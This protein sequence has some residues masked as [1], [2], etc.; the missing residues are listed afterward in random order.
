MS[1]IAKAIDIAGTQAKL[2]TLL[3]DLTGKTV[4]QQNVSSWLNSRV[5]AEWC[6]PISRATGVPLSELRPDVYEAKKPRQ[7]AVPDIKQST[8]MRCKQVL[9]QPAGEKVS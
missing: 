7:K 9:N 2:A 6:L 1:G 8:T 5:P 4:K 3:S